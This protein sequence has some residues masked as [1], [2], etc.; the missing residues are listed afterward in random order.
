[1]SWHLQNVLQPPKPRIFSLSFDHLLPLFPSLAEL[2]AAHEVNPSLAWTLFSASLSL[3]DT[4]AGPGSHLVFHA[5]ARA[6]EDIWRKSHSPA[7]RWASLS[8][9]GLA[10]Q[11]ALSSPQRPSV[12]YYCPLSVLKHSVRTAPPLTTQAGANSDI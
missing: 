2:I 9:G 1:M 8:T 10:R 5:H 4:A 6:A 11:R 12:R 3:I 7:D